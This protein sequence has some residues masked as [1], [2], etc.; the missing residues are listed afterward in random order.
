[1]YKFVT[2]FTLQH[3]TL[4]RDQTALY[5]ADEYVGAG[6]MWLKKTIFLQFILSYFV[7]RSEYK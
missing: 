2:Q 7:Q 6:R 4:F 1:V 3:I 5:V